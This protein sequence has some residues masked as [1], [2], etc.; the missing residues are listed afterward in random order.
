MNIFSDR[1]PAR[2]IPLSLVVDSLF[3]SLVSSVSSF[4][5]SSDLSSG[6][7]VSRNGYCCRKILIE[8]GAG[9]RRLTYWNYNSVRSSDAA[10]VFLGEG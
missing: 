9:V 5:E 3:A 6:A 2:S 1:I 4:C 7:S 10:S 8:R